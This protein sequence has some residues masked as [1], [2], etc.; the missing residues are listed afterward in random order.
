LAAACLLVALHR[1]AADEPVSAVREVYDSQAPTEGFLPPNEAIARIQAPEGFSV[2]LF[3]SEPQVRQPIA[4]TTDTRGRLWI[5]ENYT[6]AENALNFDT[7]LRDRILI[8]D[9][10]NHDGVADDV[11][12]FWDQGVRLTSVEL[13]YGGV[14]A[15]CP[16]H[17]LFIPDRNA[18]DRPDGPPVVVLDGWDADSVRHNIANGLKWGPDG[19]LYGRHGILAT[20]Q[21]GPP[22][23]PPDLR[24]PI[25]C[26]V[27][28]F[29]P[30][31]GTFE[32]VAHGT[33]NPWGM[34]WDEHGEPFFI[35]TVIGHLWHVVPGA[36]YQRMYGEDLNPHLY[37]LLPQTADHFHWDTAE[38]WNDI[39][40]LGV[41][42][43]TD[44]AG[45][46]HAHSGLLIY[47]GGNWPDEY[48]NRLLTLNL[49]GRRINHDR[50]ERQGAAYVA[51]H[52]PDLL[53]TGD[54]WFRG[55]DM[56]LSRDGGV[57]IAD[58]S[59]TGECHEND[60]VHRSSGRIYK[61]VYGT[62]GR[63]EVD[64]VF[65][66]NSR[67][68]VDLLTKD[69]AWYAR[70][71]QRV[72]TQRAAAGRGLRSVRTALRTL[73]EQP[74]DVRHRLRALGCLYCIGEIDEKF[75]VQHLSDP[76]EHVRAWLVRLLFDKGPPTASSVARLTDLAASDP[77]GLVL[78]YLASGLQRLPLA[79]RWPLALALANRA[80]FSA[81]PW[82]PLMIWYGV[83][84][85]VLDRPDRAAALLAATPM[86]VLKRVIARRMTESIESSPAVAKELLAELST[87]DA[88]SA[89]QILTGMSQALAGWRRVAMPAGWPDVARSLQNHGEDVSRLVREL[90]A[91]F[92]DGR[93][94]T[95]LL[96]LVGDDN[97]DLAARRSALKFL[98]ADA[99][100]KLL[101]LLN[102]LLTHRELSADAARALAAFDSPQIPQWLL[103]V[104]PRLS[105]PARVEAIET[106]TSRP[107]GAGPLLAAVAQGELPRELVTPF[108]VRRMLALGSDEINRQV[109]TLWPELRALSSERA[110]RKAH[111]KERLTPDVLATAD[112]TAGR[113]VFQRSCAQCHTLFGTGGK[114]GPDL[115]GSQ[116]AN[117]DYLLENLVD[118][119]AT[120]SPGY[121]TSAVVL[122]DGR[123]ILGAIVAR[124]ERT[125][126]VQTPAELLDVDVNKVEEIAQT[127]QSLMPDGLLDVLTE[128]QA[129]DLA[130]YLMSPTQV[131]LPEE[132]VAS[133]S[134]SR[135]AP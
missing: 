21:V 67:A 87:A 12:L 14:W 2:S 11:R 75:L 105:P 61:V 4:I 8:L 62:H 99:D 113:A 103:G 124:R 48:R 104:F 125:L 73:F 82:L 9:D 66:E 20:S 101:P 64:D 41:T 85:A 18:D 135:G 110:L 81:D 123:V 29:H 38:A 94:A 26:G 80:E 129:R 102:G 109:A 56:A 65:S 68:L 60:G 22:G 13:G 78:L 39:R 33:T 36:H 55:V 98:A 16:P 100:P 52:A 133:G 120:V 79:E 70:Q 72:L 37:E 93:A 126:R 25:N 134:G 92:G 17:L 108:Q 119:S 116:R 107:S 118:P 76:D 128:T 130:A 47:Q 122:E 3:A 132:P 10:L 31:R 69:N 50:L 131:S 83:E 112:R 44:Q 24:I 45:G 27:W 127:A 114:I 32:A 63:P 91:L 111:W 115:T 28:R 35:N 88:P 58:W 30:V 15:L 19:W 106:L 6:Y 46:G 42:P 89:R 59:D 49:H 57:F 90:S 40:N 51:R 5:A 7:S 54:P 77:S 23:T 1:L 95:E 96:A 43:T 53:R 74:A 97:G 34:D 121:F 86:P 84:P 71:A 117:L